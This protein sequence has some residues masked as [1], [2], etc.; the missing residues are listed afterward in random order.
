MGGRCAFADAINTGEQD[1]V[2]Q[3]TFP[4]YLIESIKRL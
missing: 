2:G 1:G 3:L 4:Q